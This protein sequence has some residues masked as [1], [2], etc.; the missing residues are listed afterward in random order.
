MIVTD[1]RLYVQEYDM[2]SPHAVER[3]RAVL[4][5]A[6]GMPALAVKLLVTSICFWYLFNKTN[7]AL[8]TGAAMTINIAWATLAIGLL[9]L[10]LPLAGLRLAEIVRALA[11]LARNTGRGPMLAITSI[12]IFFSQLM[13]SM[14][15]E[16]IR[17][18]M[19]ADLGV[20]W[21]M[22]LVS[23]LIDRGIGVITIVALGFIT[24]LARSPLTVT[25]GHRVHALLILGG[26]VA[27]WTGGLL[28]A[29]QVGAVLVLHRSTFWLGRFAAITH[30]VLVRS[31]AR[32]PVLLLALLIHGFS[33]AAI[34]ALAR[35]EGLLLPIEDAAALFTIIAGIAIIPVSIGNWGLREVGVTAI[36]ELRGIPV[37]QALFFSISIGIAFFLASIPG[38]LLWIIYSPHLNRGTD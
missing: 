8:F 11:P 4:S 33:V 19:L 31:H 36:L 10:Q 35:A 37:E 5:R 1:A 29:D 38:A 18:R 32:L 17:V 15:G 20:D 24:L 27:I 21:R 2:M 14:F 3:D 26:V 34:W 7:S 6:G 23:V 22:G 25:D 30:E 16:G 12:S 28:L 13:P 9:M